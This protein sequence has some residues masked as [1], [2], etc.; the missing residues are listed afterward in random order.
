MGYLG[1]DVQLVSEYMG[2]EY[3]REDW[4]E[5]QQNNEVVGVGEVIQGECIEGEEVRVQRNRNI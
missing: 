4:F 3:E 5:R 1:V 2:V